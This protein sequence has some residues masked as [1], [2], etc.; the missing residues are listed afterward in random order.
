MA[1]TRAERAAQIA[2]LFKLRAEIRRRDVASYVA[3]GVPISDPELQ[4][5]LAAARTEEE[6]A[7]IIAQCRR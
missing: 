4:A 3:Q 6:V 2:G 5:R 7:A 1:L